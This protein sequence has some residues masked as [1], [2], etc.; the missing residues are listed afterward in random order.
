MKFQVRVG[1]LIV[2]SMFT[3]PA[4]KASAQDRLPPIPPDRMTEAQKKAAQQFRKLQQSDPSAPPWSV[5]MRIPDMVVPSLEMR[6]HNRTNSALS[7]K[8]T[9]FAILIAARHWT[10]NYEW[11]AHYPAA[12]RAGLSQ[13]ILTALIEGRRPETMAKDEE[14]LFNFCEELLHNQS[15][16]DPTY[17]RALAEF[18]EPGVVEAASLEGYYSFLAIVMN[19]ARAPL[20]Q[21]AKPALQPFPRN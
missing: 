1:S 9:E 6:I 19:A 16:S 12:A 14:I 8:L 17:G 3:L 11:N 7:P 2:F 10:N 4:T 13:S 18:G 15:V 5:L 21:G 20:P